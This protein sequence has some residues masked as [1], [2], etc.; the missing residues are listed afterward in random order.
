MAEIFSKILPHLKSMF[1]VRN[2]RNNP[3]RGVVMGGDD[4]NRPEYV[5]AVVEKHHIGMGQNTSYNKN[6]ANEIRNR[7]IKTNDKKI[8]EF[9]ILPDQCG[10]IIACSLGGHMEPCNLIPQGRTSNIRHYHFAENLIKRHVSS[11]KKNPW[12]LIQVRLMYEDTEYPNRP[13]KFYYSYFLFKDEENEDSGKEVKLVPLLPHGV[14][15]RVKGHVVVRART[16]VEPNRVSTSKSRVWEGIAVGL[17]FAASLLS[18]FGPTNIPT[19]PAPAPVPVPEPVPLPV[20]RPTSPVVLPPSLP[21]TVY[22]KPMQIFVD[23]SN[24]AQSLVLAPA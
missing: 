9:N 22:S 8:K 11:T 6:L 5:I 19:L 3:I 7:G 14:E 18:V 16:R 24:L 4:G 13:T 2:D 1:R 20:P 12:A 15:I 23:T 10:H 21:V 17:Q